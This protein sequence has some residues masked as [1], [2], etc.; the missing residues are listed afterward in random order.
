MS[1]TQFRNFLS[2][3]DN[4][5]KDQ[6]CWQHWRKSA[7]CF[8]SPSFSPFLFL[9]LPC[10]LSFFLNI[11]IPLTGSNNLWVSDSGIHSNPKCFLLCCSQAP[12]S[13]VYAYAVVW[14]IWVKDLYSPSKCSSHWIKHLEATCCVLPQFLVGTQVTVLSASCH[15]CMCSQP[16]YESWT[17]CN[18]GQG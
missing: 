11:I 8:F 10:L 6:L 15:L 16:S 14:G 18:P 17:E 2:F 9:F 4:I 7:V 13:S 1:C 3:W 5:P 12:S